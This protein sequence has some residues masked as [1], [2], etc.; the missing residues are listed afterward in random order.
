MPGPRLRFRGPPRVL[1]PVFR[2]RGPPRVP[3]PVPGSAA[4]PRSECGH[5][6]RPV[7]QATSGAVRTG[8]CVP[9]RV[10]VTPFGHGGVCGM[11][12]FGHRAGRGRA[13]GAARGRTAQAV[14]D[15]S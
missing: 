5:R 6:P 8:A 11:T 10:R 7:T 1:R 14:T 9:V 3:W 12:A 2:L 4:R 13:R 15:G